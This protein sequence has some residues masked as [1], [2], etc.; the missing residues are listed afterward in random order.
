MKDKCQIRKDPLGVVLVIGAFNY[1]IQLALC[2]LV[3]AVSA[4]NTV[5]LAPSEQADATA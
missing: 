3:G 4:G 2:P 5:V 1:P